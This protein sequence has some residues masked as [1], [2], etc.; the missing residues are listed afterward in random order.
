LLVATGKELHIR[1]AMLVVVQSTCIML[2]CAQ[3]SQQP[4]KFYFET[5]KQDFCLFVKTL[6]SEV[7]VALE[8]ANSKIFS[9]DR[10]NVKKK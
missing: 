5:T 9:Y 10:L 8:L 6:F 3:I 1:V 7:E 4:R 2:G